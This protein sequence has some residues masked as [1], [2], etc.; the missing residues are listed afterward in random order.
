M[1]ATGARDMRSGSICPQGNIFGRAEV[2]IAIVAVL[3]AAFIVAF[4]AETASLPSEWWLVLLA[5]VAPLV[6]L[7]TA[8]LAASLGEKVRLPDAVS[9]GVLV[10]GL[11][12]IMFALGAFSPFAL[13]L[14]GRDLNEFGGEA[15]WYSQLI[16]GVLYGAAGGAVVGA[17]CGVA[18]WALHFALGL[19]P[20]DREVDMKEGTR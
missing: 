9:T 7:L 16:L 18:A 14:G 12:G 15:F 11:V 2:R 3:A 20:V 8:A 17:V 13:A 4:A 10:G 19:K 1:L 6:L 5:V